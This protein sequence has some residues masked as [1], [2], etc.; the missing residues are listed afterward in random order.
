MELY[1]Y[2][3]TRLDEQNDLWDID[4]IWMIEWLMIECI[5]RVVIREP[6]KN[7]LADFFR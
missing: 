2:R 6:V 3:G 7:Y 1:F 5:L 4:G